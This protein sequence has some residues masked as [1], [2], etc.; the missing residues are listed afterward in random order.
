[1][2]WEEGLQILAQFY[3]QVRFLK[4]NN[5]Y[6]GPPSGQIAKGADLTVPDL[7]HWYVLFSPGN[8]LN[9]F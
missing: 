2:A 8:V 4:E 5:S 6:W 7:P 9:F 3:T 1:M